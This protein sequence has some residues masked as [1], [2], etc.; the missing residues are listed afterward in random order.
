MR[1]LV[2]N[3]TDNA[4]V[5]I[6]D[7]LLEHD[8]GHWQDAGRFRGHTLWQRA[9]DVMVQVDGPTIHDETLTQDLADTGWP[10]GAVW[11][12]SRHRAA[13]GKPSLTVHPIG[14][15]GRESRFGGRPHTLSPAAPRDMAALLRALHTLRDEHALP[16][17]VTYEST[18]HGPLMVQ[19]SLFVEVGSDETWYDDV[20]SAQA[21]A[22][23]VIQVLDA[24]PGDRTAGHDA[25]GAAE[26]ATVETATAGAQRRG[27]ARPLIVVGVGGGHYVPQHTEK[28]IAGAYDF[29]HFVPAYAIDAAAP[30]AADAV[31]LTLARALAATPGASGVYVHKKGLKGPQ[32]EL[33][34]AALAALRVPALAAAPDP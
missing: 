11:F 4:S 9:Y 16:H 34:R 21:L 1:V 13:S 12:L 2:V 20:P 31:R 32:R 6:R 10:I 19:P 33:V 8:D 14:N 30:D 23:A 15:H 27:G 29:G 25:A 18:H 7:R 17:E 5:N 26:E 22:A 24:G 3:R 28:A